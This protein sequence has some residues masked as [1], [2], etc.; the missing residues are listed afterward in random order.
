MGYG[1][2][3]T[4]L[5]NRSQVAWGVGAMI[6]FGG[7][8]APLNPGL[9]KLLTRTGEQGYIERVGLKYTC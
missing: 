2:S 5:E 4:I 1:I 8:M 3:Y 6:Q 7:W 9:G